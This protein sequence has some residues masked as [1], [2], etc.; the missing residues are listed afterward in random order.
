M[1]TIQYVKGITFAS[2]TIY[3]GT[4]QRYDFYLSD[5]FEISDEDVFVDA[6][7][8][9]KTAKVAFYIKGI[10][11]TIIDF[12]G[13]TLDFHGRIVPFILRNCK[14]VKLMNFKV[15]YDRP[16]YT[17][18]DVISASSS[19]LEVKINQGFDYRTENGYL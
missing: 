5:V 19:E 4:E 10:E 12:Q 1:N 17:Q 15:D 9:S 18:A 16:F 3:R 6:N 2:N 11:N 13:A 14:N 7:V 8:R